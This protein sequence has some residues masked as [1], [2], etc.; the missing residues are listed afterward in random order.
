MGGVSRYVEGEVQERIV[1]FL[2]ERTTWNE[3]KLERAAE[4]LYDDL[5]DFIKED[6]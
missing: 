5:Y 3:F 6:M 2:R 4:E 1:D